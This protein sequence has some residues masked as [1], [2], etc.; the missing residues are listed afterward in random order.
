MSEPR[1][2][3]L[4]ATVALAEGAD[5]AAVGA[6]VTVAL[7]G[8]WRHTGPCRWPHNNALREGGRFRTLFVAADEDALAVR[9]RI[10][11]ALRGSRA[12]EVLSL[13]AREVAEDERALAQR[14]V[15]GPRR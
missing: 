8:D 7:C 9:A 14:L 5:P 10:E 2:H 12:W 13:G 4:E 15:T 1:A 11:A 3:V 6:A